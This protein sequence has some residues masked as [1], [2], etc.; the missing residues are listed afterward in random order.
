MVPQL[1]VDCKKSKNEQKEAS[2]QSY[3]QFTIVIYDSRCVLTVKLPILRLYSRNL[4]S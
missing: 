4:R 1:L 2:G 3:Q